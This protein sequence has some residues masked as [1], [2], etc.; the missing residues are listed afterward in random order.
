LKK[1]PTNR[2]LTNRITTNETSAQH[3]FSPP[4]SP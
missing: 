3:A 1:D 2:D 4:A